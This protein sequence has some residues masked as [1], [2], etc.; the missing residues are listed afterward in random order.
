MTL[1]SSFQ[2]MVPVGCI[3]AIIIM[4]ILVVSLIRSFL[5]C[6]K[7]AIDTTPLEMSSVAVFI[8]YIFYMMMLP[9]SRSVIDPAACHIR[10]PLMSVT[11]AFA[12][13]SLFLFCDSLSS[14]LRRIRLC[15]LQMRH[16]QSSR[17]YHCILW[18]VRCS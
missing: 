8:T 5:T 3:I 15:L 12:R 11:W 1:V 16:P 10:M 7:G 17:C 9:L 6:K 13:A 14:F 2:D 4:T 18:C